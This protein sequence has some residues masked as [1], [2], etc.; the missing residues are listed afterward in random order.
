MVGTLSA[1]AM[2]PRPTEWLSGWM[3]AGAASLTRADPSAVMLRVRAP[4]VQPPAS[5][6]ITQPWPPTPQ[7]ML[8]LSAWVN[9]RFPR[10]TC[11]AYQGAHTAREF[12]RTF[13]EPPRVSGRV[14]TR[15]GTSPKHETWRAGESCLLPHSQPMLVVT[16]LSEVTLNDKENLEK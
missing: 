12:S 15:T 10:L 6:P 9:S 3:G 1:L 7:M 13:F 8:L 16:T 4:W 2:S 5:R 14:Q 11:V